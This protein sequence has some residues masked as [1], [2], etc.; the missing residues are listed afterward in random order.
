MFKINYV[1]YFVNKHNIE[2]I[3][4]KNTKSEKKIKKK[5]YRMLQTDDYFV[6]KCSVLRLFFN[7]FCEDRIINSYVVNYLYET[8]LTCNNKIVFMF[9]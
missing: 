7:E 4:N 3:F 9:T 6:Y 2:S 8:I 5:L 1:K